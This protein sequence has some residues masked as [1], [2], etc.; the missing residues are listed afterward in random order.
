[1][2]V[3]SMSKDATEEQIKNTIKERYA[4]VDSERLDGEV[5]KPIRSSNCDFVS[6]FGRVKTYPVLDESSGT[7]MIYYGGVAHQFPDSAGVLYA[8]TKRCG[9][10]DVG[11]EVAV[12]FLGESDS[13]VLRH[14]DGN[15]KNN[16]LSNLQWVNDRSK[17]IPVRCINNG[18]VY[19][20]ILAASLDCCVSRTS[21][22]RS[23]NE[24]HPVCGYQFEYVR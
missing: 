23:L 9:T 20:S 14:I 1:M 5:W 7:K 21:I 6:N 2:I 11:L 10:V 15:P 19:E 13:K 18:V 8:S 12:A 24:N 16:M 3:M 22:R 4:A 17:K